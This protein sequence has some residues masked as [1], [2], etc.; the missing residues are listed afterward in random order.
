MLKFLFISITA[1]LFIVNILK[2][3]NFIKLNKIQDKIYHFAMFFLFA[4][5]IF[6]F[7]KNE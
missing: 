5:L 1:V 4:Y 3:L 7:F 2:G 6:L